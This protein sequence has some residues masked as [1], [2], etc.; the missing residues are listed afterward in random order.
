MILLLFRRVGTSVIEI[1]LNVQ[2][3]KCRACR[4]EGK[5]TATEKDE[6]NP[7]PKEI[8]IYLCGQC[9]GWGTV[10]RRRLE[11]ED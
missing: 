9:N 2:E 10:F 5:Y 3:V 4:G 1:N 6:T 7:S 8:R 11:K